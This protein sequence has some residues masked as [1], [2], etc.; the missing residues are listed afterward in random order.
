M[1]KAKYQSIESLIVS[2]EWNRFDQFLII[3]VLEEKV[4]EVVKYK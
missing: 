4:H 3:L 2:L 1:Y